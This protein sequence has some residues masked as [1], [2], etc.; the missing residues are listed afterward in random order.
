MGYFD[1]GISLSAPDYTAPCLTMKQAGVDVLFVQANPSGLPKILEQCASQQYRPMVAEIFGSISNGSLKQ[2][3]MNGVHFWSPQANFQDETIP[4]V[5][6]FADAMQ[7]YAGSAWTNDQFGPTYT[8]TWA[9][10]EMYKAAAE[11]GKL[12]P[13]SD[14]A[15]VLSG[16]YALKDE[17]LDGLTAP[18]TY[19][20]GKFIN[21][22]CY[23]DSTIENGK[24]VGGS[25]PTCVDASAVN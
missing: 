19:Q 13:G 5:K 8:N 22:N 17:T 10:L 7:K 6:K 20:K 18:Q 4:G 14:Y 12:G 23:F 1:T 24:F 15:A 9:S 3:I 11:A 25:K 2:P 16:L 21:P